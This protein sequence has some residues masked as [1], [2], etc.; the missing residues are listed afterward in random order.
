[1]RVV[2]LREF[3]TDMNA[4]ALDINM[5]IILIGI[6]VAVSF[7]AFNRPSV[8]M[9]LM[10]NPF[11]ISRKQQYYRFLTSGFIHR[12]H[13]HL[14]MNMI[15][16]YFLGTAV[17][18]V[19]D[20]LFGPAGSVYFVAL[21]L[22]A[23]IVS[24]LPTYFQKRNS[25]AYNSLGASG[26]VAAV[27]FA[28]IIFQPMQ[29]ICIFFAL[30]MPGFILGILYIGYSYFQ[31]KRSNDNINHDAHLYG[32]LFGL[33]FCLIVYPPSFMNFVREVSGWMSGQ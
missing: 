17:E 13:M 28:F 11:S 24:D 6:T 32:S 22:L 2:I 21:Y 3:V 8:L 20:Y 14:L 25:P 19:F 9:A 7:Y 5:T 26:G 12:D 27:V 10:M 30:C 16:F 15:S 4:D 31:G 1:M 23:I 18:Q 33:L 29:Y